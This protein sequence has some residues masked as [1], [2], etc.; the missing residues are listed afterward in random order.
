MSEIICFVENLANYPFR[1]RLHQIWV[2]RRVSLRT[3]LVCTACRRDD[4]S[5]STILFESSSY[6]RRHK[7]HTENLGGRKREPV[8]LVYMTIAGDVDFLHVALYLSHFFFHIA[9]SPL[10]YSHPFLAMLSVV[11]PLR[12][13]FSPA[14]LEYISSFIHSSRFEFF[15]LTNN[16]M[17]V[18]M[19]A[20][21][22]TAHVFSFLCGYEDVCVLEHS[23]TI[24]RGL[25]FT[26]KRIQTQV[27][28]MVYEKGGGSKRKQHR[29]I[30]LG[31][32]TRSR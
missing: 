19:D 22:F 6:I 13:C 18:C 5:Q 2:I 16:G 31:F 9:L 27:Y 15:L 1:I 4:K 28:T 14:R 29:R 32:V 21:E 30:S 12:L 25:P 26:L 8:C 11:P 20:V 23:C 17:Q 24:L 7:S 3:H 10:E